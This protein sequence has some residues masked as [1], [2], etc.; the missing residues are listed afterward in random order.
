[1]INVEVYSKNLN[2]STGVGINIINITEMIEKC[3]REIN[4]KHGLCV[5]YSPRTTTAMIINEDEV[6]L[7]SDIIKVIEDIFKPR[8]DWLHNKVD[9]NAYAHL[10][11]I[12][13]GSSRVIPITNGKLALGTWQQIFLIEMNGPRTR[14]I[15]VLIVGE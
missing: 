4:V 11:S 14:T 12:F 10:G 2:I 9:K 7:R 1:M 6:D 15:Q 5:V 13:L 8:G 3:V